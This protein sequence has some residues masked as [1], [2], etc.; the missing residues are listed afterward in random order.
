MSIKGFNVNGVTEQ[1][2]YN[3]LDNKPEIHSIPTGG[4]AGQ[5]LAKRSGADYAVEWADQTG[6]GGG[7]TTDYNDL[8]NKPQINGNALTGNKTAANLGLISAPAS[9]TAGQFLVYD[10]SAWVAQTVPSASGVSF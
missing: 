1:Y 2:D 4:T 10:G 5:V 9:A 8:S 6:G 7:G 3:S